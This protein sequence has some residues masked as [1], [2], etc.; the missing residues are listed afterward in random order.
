MGSLRAQ[1]GPLARILKA[2]ARTRIVTI[3]IISILHCSWLLK[4]LVALNAVLPTSSEP[5]DQVEMCVLSY[6]EY[7]GRRYKRK[8]RGSPKENPS[9]SPHP[10]PPPKPSL[11][12]LKKRRHLYHKPF[13]GRSRTV[14]P[15][16]TLAVTSQLFIFPAAVQ[17]GRNNHTATQLEAVSPTWR[18]TF[19]N[20]FAI[21]RRQAAANWVRP[22]LRTLPLGIRGNCGEELPGL[23]LFHMFFI[24]LQ[25]NKPFTLSPKL[26]V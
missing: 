24:Q 26:L 25:F 3:F 7:L 18:I 9:P 11:D 16:L 19:P 17:E 15:H 13:Q 2:P 10:T 5:Q 22:A 21:R 12:G 4:L 1:R 8:D 23:P 20:T 6:P 14:S